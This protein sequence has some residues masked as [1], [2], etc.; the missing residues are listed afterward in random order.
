M[1][2]HKIRITAYRERATDPTEDH[3]HK[4]HS[5]VG[6]IGYM[7]INNKG[8]EVRR[9]VDANGVAYPRRAVYEYEVIDDEPTLPDWGI[10][11]EEPTL[12]EVP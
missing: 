1:K 5:K 10:V 8:T 6:T 11:D 3:Q 12:P 7:V 4:S 9:I 2:Y